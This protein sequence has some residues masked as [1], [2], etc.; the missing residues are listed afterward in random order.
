MTAL[1][2]G[3]GT[4]VLAQALTLAFDF[5]GPCH[6]LLTETLFILL[7]HFLVVLT[8]IAVQGIVDAFINL[9]A[10]VVFDG[11]LGPVLQAV[12]HITLCRGTTTEQQQR[13]YQ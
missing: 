1:G 12:E 2:A 7:A 13:R 8:H 3:P 11:V 4:V 5:L 6:I 9:V 10:N